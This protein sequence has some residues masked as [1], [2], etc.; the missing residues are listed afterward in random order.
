[1]HP[2]QPAGR[3][4]CTMTQVHTA[5][6]GLGQIVRHRDHAFH[7]LVMDV[8]A[9]YAGPAAETGVVA[10]DQPFYRILIAD[11]EGGVIAYAAEE[12]LVATPEIEPLT[13]EAEREW[14]TIDA[15]G[16]HAPRSQTLQ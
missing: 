6:F 4:D 15:R 10:S 9:S 8:D 12:A 2:L 14:F 11:A 7:G 3:I 16:R 13:I 5:R 1:M